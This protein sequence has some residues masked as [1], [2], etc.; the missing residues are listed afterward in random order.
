M[1]TWGVVPPLW[2][3][4]IEGSVRWSPSRYRAKRSINAARQPAVLGNKNS[5]ETEHNVKKRY[6]VTG[7]AATLFGG[8]AYAVSIS[9]LADQATGG[10]LGTLTATW[11]SGDTCTVGTYQYNQNKSTQHFSCTASGTLLSASTNLNGRLVLSDFS[12]STKE[13]PPKEE[14]PKK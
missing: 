14:P 1:S 2:N 9:N 7:I 10:L 8:A 12:C 13:E 6:L 5:N 4:A 3:I 11:S